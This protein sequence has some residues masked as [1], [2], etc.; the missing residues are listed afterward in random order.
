MDGKKFEHESFG[1]ITVCKT[2]STGTHLFG[3]E[4]RHHHFV[5]VQVNRADVTRDLSHDWIHAGQRLIEFNMTESQWA[6]FV[7]SFSDGGG[8]PITLRYVDGK[9]MEPCPIPEDSHDTFA[10]EVKERV[11]DVV[12]D[13]RGL[14]DKLAETLKPGNKTL[15]KKELQEVLRTVDSAVMQ[16][17]NNLPYI[18]KCFN[19]SMEK[20]MTHAKIEFEAIVSHRLQQMGL[21]NLRKSLPESISENKE[22]TDGGN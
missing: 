13:L 15:G 11:D 20:K 6:H 19:E 3:S 7:S 17:T 10:A 8:T 16:V 2:S 9:G 1:N 18:E 4:A 12:K 5:H 22:L 14:R 21:E